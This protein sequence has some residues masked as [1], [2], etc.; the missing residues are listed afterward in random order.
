MLIPDYRETSVDDIDETEIDAHYDG[1]NDSD[2]V[3]NGR[4]KVFYVVFVPKR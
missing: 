3:D 4:F 1:Y 2:I